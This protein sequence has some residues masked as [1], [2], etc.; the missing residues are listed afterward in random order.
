MRS[1]AGGLLPGHGRPD[2][3][4]AHFLLGGHRWYL[5]VRTSSRSSSAGGNKHRRS[6]S[7]EAGR[8]AAPPV[9]RDGRGAFGRNEH[10]NHKRPRTAT[11]AAFWNTGGITAIA[12]DGSRV[13]SAAGRGGGAASSGATS[14]AGDV[15]D[16]SDDSGDGEHDEY[17]VGTSGRPPVI[18]GDADPTVLVAVSIAN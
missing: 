12:I 1:V 18:K 16:V 10:Q 9:T 2:R 15:I 8:E 14:R 5:S 6:Q 13:G 4:R 11:G 3:A 7:Q 17:R